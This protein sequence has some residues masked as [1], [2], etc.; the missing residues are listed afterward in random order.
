MAKSRKRDKT[1]VDDIR[2]IRERLGA[3]FDNDVDRLAEHARKVAEEYRGKLSLKPV[4]APK[5]DC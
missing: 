2:R 3:E 5:N 4:A 1:P